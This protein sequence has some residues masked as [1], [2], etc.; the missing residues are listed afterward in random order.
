MVKNP[1][2]VGSDQVILR[3]EYITK[4]RMEAMNWDMSHHLVLL[5]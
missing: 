3:D 2:A 1:T 4:L 5:T